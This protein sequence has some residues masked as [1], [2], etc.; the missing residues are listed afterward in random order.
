M[1]LLSSQATPASP[2]SGVRVVELCNVAAGPYCAM[3]L[4]DMGAEVIKIESKEG[5]ALRQ[6]PPISN[7]FSE[8]FASL[9][10]NKRSIALDLKDQND[11]LV[12]RRLI[13]QSDI[14]I[15][16]NRPGALARLG[17]G[18]ETFAKDLPGLIYCSLSAFGQEGPRASQGGFD[19][20]VQAI[21]GIMS[22]TGEQDRDPVKAGIP[23][24]DFATAL[25]GA[26]AIT[27]LLSRVRAGGRGGYIDVSMF[28]T[29]LAISA[30]QTSEY[31]GTG[32]DPKRLGAAHPRN[33]PYQAFRAIDGEFVVAAGNE[34][35]WQNVCTV[36]GRR[37][38]AEDA[39]FKTTKDRA[40]NQKAL[41][42]IF[43]AIFAE[44]TVEDIIGSLSNAGVPCAPINSYSQALDDPQVHFMN[45]VQP[46]VLPGGTETRTFATPVRIDGQTAPIRTAPPALDADRAAI[47]DELLA[48]EGAPKAART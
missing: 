34:K 38:L 41:A 1:C 44:R 21:S 35:L 5:D 9:N 46:M 29:S 25:L 22:V 40:D 2:L 20:T 4:A 13:A 3:L 17:L 8:N 31:F 24:S 10:R 43:T 7:G 33:A 42:E 48:R 37:D 23:V 11:N 15:E 30:L 27:S 16:N 18:H 26:F 47:L 36:I 45:W 19:L 14:V 12:A 6:W 39:R 28:G 32:Q